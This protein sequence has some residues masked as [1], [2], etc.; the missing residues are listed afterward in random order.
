MSVLQA[1][2]GR[3]KGPRGASKWNA[4]PDGGTNEPQ[5]R[6]RDDPWIEKKDRNAKKSVDP[7]H[8]PAE[9]AD[10]LGVESLPQ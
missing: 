1:P 4:G 9:L 6:T 7:F 5:G 8:M 3:Y 2:L 10:G